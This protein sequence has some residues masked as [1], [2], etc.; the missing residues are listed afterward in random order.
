[1]SN[2]LWLHRSPGWVTWRRRSPVCTLTQ[3]P[4]HRG[5]AARGRCPRRAA[6]HIPPPAPCRRSA[7]GFNTAS[8]CSR[9]ATQ[10]PRG[11][12]LSGPDGSVTAVLVNVSRCADP[13]A[14]SSGPG[15][16]GRRTTVPRPG[17]DQRDHLLDGR[18]DHARATLA[19]PLVGSELFRART[20]SP[21]TRITSRAVSSSARSHAISAASAALAPALPGLGPRRADSVANAPDHAD[22]A[23]SVGND[24]YSSPAT[25]MPFRAIGAVIH[26]GSP[27]CTS[28]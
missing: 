13:T 18:V 22:G 12:A 20:V 3:Q 6:W 7:A 17:P 28:R 11:C 10:R 2:Q 21:C 24:E 15:S 26:Q 14:V 16:R 19:S 4:L 1:M 27:A 25:G 9:S 5:L 8:T 23:I